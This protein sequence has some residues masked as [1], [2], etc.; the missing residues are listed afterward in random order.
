MPES[1]YQSLSFPSTPF[2]VLASIHFARKAEEELTFSYRLAR[3]QG[4]SP[5]RALA[6]FMLTFILT[7]DYDGLN[8]QD[9]N[10]G[11][12]LVLR[13]KPTSI[14]SPEDRPAGSSH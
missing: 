4:S 10:R 8:S 14:D 13:K 7:E 6:Q 5:V 1:P 11:K 12:I 3:N 2:S 9:G